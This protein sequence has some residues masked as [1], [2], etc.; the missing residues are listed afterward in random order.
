ME[1]QNIFWA[2]IWKLK[3]LAGKVLKPLYG[4]GLVLKLY[5]PRLIEIF[6]NESSAILINLLKSP[7]S[8]ILHALWEMWKNQTCLAARVL[9]NWHRGKSP[10]SSMARVAVADAN[11]WSYLPLHCGPCG[12]KKISACWKFNMTWFFS[13]LFFLYM[14]FDIIASIN[15]NLLWMYF[16]KELKIYILPF[17]I[18][19]DGFC[20]CVYIY[21]YMWVQITPSECLGPRSCFHVHVFSFSFVPCAYEQ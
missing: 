11:N 6:F 13:L 15:K 18:Y 16:Y 3:V 12:T 21:I 1:P 19:Y 14:T 9:L 2:A 20:V 8:T 7:T 10:I 17:N 4:G 5:Q